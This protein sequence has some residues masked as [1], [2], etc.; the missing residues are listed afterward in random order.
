MMSEDIEYWKRLY[1]S[2]SQA[3]AN[4]EKQVERQQAVITMLNENIA[5]A[6]MAVDTHKAI[7]RNA[8]EDFNRKEQEYIGLINLLKDKLRELGY[9]DF[10]N[11][12]N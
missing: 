8:I 9:A 1:R 5:N 10:N 4:L 11:L 7:N 3:N 6:Q 2:L 12:G